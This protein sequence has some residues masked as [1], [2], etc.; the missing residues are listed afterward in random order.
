MTASI[1]S[2]TGIRS[3]AALVGVTPSR[4]RSNS[5]AFT[6][7][8]SSTS[9]R[10]TVDASTPSAAAATP[11]VDERHSARNSRTSSQ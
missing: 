4:P 10:E 6:A 9:R 7:S 1:S 5:V 8:S 2:A 11:T 3:S